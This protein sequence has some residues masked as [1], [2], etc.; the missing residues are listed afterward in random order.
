MTIEQGEIWLINLDPT[1]G[2]EIAKSR[3]GIVVNHDEIGVLPL[4]T[5]V[6]ITDWKDR[7]GEYPWMLRLE[8]DEING[9]KKTSAV[10]AFQIKNISERRFIKRLGHIDTATLREI[11]RKI[12]ATL[13]LDLI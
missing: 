1:I 12:I 10:D 2:A 5:V 13:D 8:P 9:L 4:K 3:P 11:H 6:P 7:Y